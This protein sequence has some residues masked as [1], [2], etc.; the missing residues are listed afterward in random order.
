MIE[1]KTITIIGATGTMGANV[2]G[3]FAS[4]G[5]AKVYCVGRDIEKVKEI[6]PKIIKS[7]KADSILS[8]LYPADF[9]MLEKCVRESDIV[10]ES[11]AE[12]FSIKEEIARRV[13][14]ALRDNAISCT[15][16]S[17]LSITALAECYPEKKRSRFFGVHF[18]NPPYNMPLCEFIST[19]YADINVANR[20]KEYLKNVLLRTVVE[21]KD[22]PAFMGNRIGFQFI[23]EALQY[24]ERYKDNGG[25]DYIDS[26]LGPFTG[27]SMAPLVTSDFVG[28]DVHKAIVD[29]VYLNT[30]DYAHNT[31]ILPEYV[32]KLI[33]ENKLGKKVGVGLY[34]TIRYDNGIK[35]HT[36]YDITTCQYRDQIL[37]VFPYAD[38]MKKRIVVGDYIN[39]FDVL[40]KNHSNE[41]EVC[42]NF[43][44]KYIVYSLY[45]ATEVGYNI[46]SADDV[47]ATGFNWCPPIALY[48]ALS[49][50]VDVRG[51]IGERLPE[52]C[53]SI[54]VNRLL[55]A[56]KCS[57][58][59]YRPYFKSG[60]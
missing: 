60:R 19:H 59:D 16:T 9:T 25:I 37:Y 57:K 29:N 14:K 52:V 4:F 22:I 53:K 54:D 35:R 13:G 26:I 56:A 21:V 5:N 51:L 3:I 28:L 33:D 38:E 30:R 11:V 40:I 45:I 10:F 41:A 1:M 2:A 27:R 48:Q 43:L 34:Q 18:F 23:N 50:V 47:M 12:E 42:M 58:Y 24:A 44:L 6:I 55:N 46:E 39:A 7:V 17:G 31:F 49:Q 32:K 20:L 8:N 36:V 15:G